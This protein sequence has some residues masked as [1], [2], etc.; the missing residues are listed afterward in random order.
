MVLCKVTIREY[1]RVQITILEVLLNKTADPKENDAV[2]HL[3]M[4]I[5]M[6]MVR[7]CEH[8]IDHQDIHI[9]DVPKIRDVG[10]LFL[11]DNR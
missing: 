4:T 11:S 7:G 8:I 6:W 1:V 2:E 9:C 10:C 3:D 5:G